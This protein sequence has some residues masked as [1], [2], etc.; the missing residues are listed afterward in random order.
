[1]HGGCSARSR[2]AEEAVS[3]QHFQAV[4]PWEGPSPL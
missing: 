1:M 3:K 2:C 4:D